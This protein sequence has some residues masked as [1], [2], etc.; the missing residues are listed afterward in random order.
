MKEETKPGSEGAEQRAIDVLTTKGELTPKVTEWP[1]DNAYA[2]EDEYYKLLKQ[3]MEAFDERD[4]EDRAHNADPVWQTRKADAK[5]NVQKAVE[6]YR[7]YADFRCTGRVVVELV[8]LSQ[9]RAVYC[10]R[11]RAADFGVFDKLNSNAGNRNS[12]CMWQHCAWPKLI[13]RAC[14]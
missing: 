14:Q 11:S 2:E 6:L 4:R 8:G 13:L 10:L 9:T 12:V 7:C 1:F 3:T 5:E